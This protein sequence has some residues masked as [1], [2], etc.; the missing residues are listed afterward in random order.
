MCGSRCSFCSRIWWLL[1]N[2]SFGGTQ[3]QRTFYAAGQTGQQLL[4]GAYSALS[5]QIGLGRVKC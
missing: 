1:D 2:R 3:V 5:R 4:L